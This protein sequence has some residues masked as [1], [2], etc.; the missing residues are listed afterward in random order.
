MPCRVTAEGKIDPILAKSGYVFFTA[1]RTDLL[2]YPKTGNYQ[3]G[4]YGGGMV[5]VALYSEHIDPRKS[6]ASEGAFSTGSQQI[7]Q[8]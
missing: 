6:G 4:V 5:M 3:A 1:S 8:K 7:R 2:G